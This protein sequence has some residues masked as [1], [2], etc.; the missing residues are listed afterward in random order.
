MKI[1]DGKR[2]FDLELDE[3]DLGALHAALIKEPYAAVALTIE[4]INRQ[5]VAQQKPVS[6]A[7]S[8]DLPPLP[9]GADYIRHQGGMPKSS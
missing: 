8:I 3:N 9:E 1:I 6:A 2:V 5:I 7:P 4:K